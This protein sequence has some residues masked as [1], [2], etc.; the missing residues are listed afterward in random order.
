MYNVFVSYLREDKTQAL[1]LANELQSNGAAVWVDVSD[2]SVGEP[3]REEIADAI[4]DAEFFLACFSST[5]EKRPIN[6]MLEELNYVLKLRS[7]GQ[8]HPE[9]LPIKLNECH[10]P[11]I[12]I[13]SDTSLNDL[14]WFLFDDQN[15]EVGVRQLLDI[16]LR[17][18]KERAR[19]QLKLAAEEVVARKSELVTAQEELRT[20]E[21]RA[22]QEHIQQ[23]MFRNSNR[24]ISSGISY[25]PP[26]VW[27][28]QQVAKKEVEHEYALSQ[29]HK[30]QVEFVKRFG[31]DFHPLGGLVDRM[32]EEEKRI[33]QSFQDE[34]QAE[35]ASINRAMS[36]VWV[37]LIGITVLIVVLFSLWRLLKWLLGF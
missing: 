19:N 5:Y 16:T 2:L 25:E 31:E 23:Q 21:R 18:A 14:H 9:I 20:H 12:R 29:Y 13:D 24:Q 11:D 26:S 37:L 33:Q 17:L 32:D 35:D 15:W 6:G 4:R 28:A 3:W 22:I 1:R 27:P 8:K 10:I 30:L 7:S 34:R 36:D